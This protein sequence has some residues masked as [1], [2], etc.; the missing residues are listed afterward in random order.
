MYLYYSI[1]KVIKWF[2]VCFF[3]NKII[4]KIKLN[5]VYL[6]NENIRKCCIIVVDVNMEVIFVW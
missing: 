3:L 4:L 2:D 6:L 5:D 1:C